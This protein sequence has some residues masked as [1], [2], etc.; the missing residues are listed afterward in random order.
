MT[1]AQPTE[2]AMAE[3]C[4]VVGRDVLRALEYLDRF[5]RPSEK[6]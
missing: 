2:L 6:A 5:C 4:F 1:A 3:V